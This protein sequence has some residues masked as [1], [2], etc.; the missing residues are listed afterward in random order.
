MLANGTVAGYGDIAYDLK[1]GHRGRVVIEIQDAFLTN[2]GPQAHVT[3]GLPGQE[4]RFRRDKR[5][6]YRPIKTATDCS[7][8]G[9]VVL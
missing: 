4:D 6:D 3:G 5:I 9:I 2:K 1:S 8:D 7:A